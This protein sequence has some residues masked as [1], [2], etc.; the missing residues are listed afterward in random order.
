MCSSDLRCCTR[1]FSSC[2]ERGLLFVAVRRLLIAVASL[3][4]EPGSRRAGPR[5]CS[6]WA[7]QLQLTGS[8][9]QAQQLWCTGPVAPRHAGSS[10]TRAR[11]RVPC[12][13]RRTPNHCATGEAPSYEFWKDTIQ[14]LTL[15]ILGSINLNGF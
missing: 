4:A 2:G 14:S 6:A 1:A 9:A 3:V 12:I 5:R 8:R 11:T 13:G 15:A 10:R 7:Q